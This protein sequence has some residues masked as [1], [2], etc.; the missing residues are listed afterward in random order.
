MT[1]SSGSPPD[2]SKS[3]LKDVNHNENGL[4]HVDRETKRHSIDRFQIVRESIPDSVL[5]QSSPPILHN[6]KTYMTDI[7]IQSY[8]ENIDQHPPPYLLKDFL[9]AGINEALGKG[10]SIILD[11]PLIH[12]AEE[13]DVGFL[14]GPNPL[15]SAMAAD[16][17]RYIFRSGKSKR[18][19]DALGAW[20]A[21]P[22]ELP[23]IERHETIY[24]KL[25]ESAKGSWEYPVRCT[26]I[27]FRSFSEKAKKRV[28]EAAMEPQD[29]TLEPI[30]ACLEDGVTFLTMA[31]VAEEKEEHTVRN[32]PGAS[33]SAAQSQEQGSEEGAGRGEEV[34]KVTPDPDS[35]L[36]PTIPKKQAAT[37]DYDIPPAPMP[38]PVDSSVFENFNPVLP[39]EPDTPFS[40]D[41]DP[42]TPLL[43]QEEH[44][45]DKLDRPPSPSALRSLFGVSDDKHSAIDIIV[46]L[47]EERPVPTANS[48][49]A[50]VPAPHANLPQPSTGTEQCVPVVIQD[51]RRPMFS[52]GVQTD[53]VDSE[54]GGVP[55]PDAASESRVSELEDVEQ[56]AGSYEAVQTTSIP[57]PVSSNSVLV[58]ASDPEEVHQGPPTAGDFQPG[59]T[60]EVDIWSFT[61]ALNIILVLQLV[62][63]L[64]AETLPHLLPSVPA[65]AQNDIA[66]AAPS[67]TQT[68]ELGQTILDEGSSTSQEHKATDPADELGR[69][70]AQA[71]PSREEESNPSSIAQVPVIGSDPSQV[72][73]QAPDHVAAAV[74]SVSSTQEGETGGL[75][76]PT[77]N[78]PS[79]PS[80]SRR[81]RPEATPP[82]AES[83]RRPSKRVRG[84]IIS[85]VEGNIEVIA[86]VSPPVFENANAEPDEGGEPLMAQERD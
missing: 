58:Q 54:E 1:E 86:P 9:Q 2:A 55:S 21:L 46:P 35:V 17:T 83:Q 44:Q 60:A 66:A 41:E 10:A 45:A 85:G 27:F 74:S 3:S 65:S 30:D 22:V 48:G 20:T 8:K 6:I 80:G 16:S 28:L 69:T 49:E 68:S 70:P 34:K 24:E 76:E 79:T 62:A 52:K 53:E 82:S 51:A 12:I 67:H 47:A 56:E 15:A 26:P 37:I 64:A 38:P 19:V 32:A 36:S 61:Y 63:A 25:A 33:P 39:P 72:G 75:T 73:A 13:G 14:V 81:S 29:R 50:D 71:Q 40:D 42:A 18:D 23:G 11:R 4:P 5:R 31:K 57:A 59:W 7:A 78:N 84:A 43:P 77:L